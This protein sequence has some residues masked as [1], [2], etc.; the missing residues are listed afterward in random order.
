MQKR[1]KSIK[2]ILPLTKVGQNIAWITVEKKYDTNAKMQVE[3]IYIQQ[4][5]ELESPG[6]SG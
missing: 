6:C 4:Q 3:F 2:Q 5:I 1:N